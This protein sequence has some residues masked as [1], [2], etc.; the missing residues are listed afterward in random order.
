MNRLI[1]LAA[2]LLAPTVAPSQNFKHVYSS[3]G[4]PSREDLARLNLKLAWRAYLPTDHRRDGIFSVQVADD[5]ILVQTRSGAIVALNAATGST[6]WRASLDVPYRVNNVLAYNTKLVFATR[7]TTM[8]AVDR[9]TGQVVWSFSLP[10]GP[11]AAPA[12]DDLHVFI[13]LSNSHLYAYEIPQAAKK[14]AVVQAEKE[15][16]EEE[17]ARIADAAAKAK[18]AAELEEERRREQYSVLGLR[19]RTHFSIAKDFE[20]SGRERLGYGLQPRLLWEYKALTRLEQPPLLTD[21]HAVIPGQDGTFVVTA[22]TRLV[23]N[24]FTFDAG[25]ALAAPLGHYAVMGDDDHLVEIAY[26]ATTDNN[27]FAIDTIKGR[28]DWRFLAGAALHSQPRVTDDDVY[29]A[30][31]PSGLYRIDRKS[32]REHWRNLEARRFLAMNKKFVY[33]LNIRGNLLVLDRGSGQPLGRLFVHDFTAVSNETNDRIFLTSNDGM[34]LC[35]HDRD[36]PTPLR[37]KNLP[38]KKPAEDKLKIEP[39]A[40]EKKA[41]ANDR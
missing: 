24:P 16:M 37:N 22:L 8:Y 41:D 34:I 38:V 29:V 12:A 19:R 10:G 14:E 2:L 13:T 40:E 18:L 36:Y 20:I 1:A 30:A 25:E 28:I 21:E 4:A 6:L 17:K 39:R 9:A 26:V 11:S 33:A 15:T 7:A 27:L 31:D 23:S 5:Q 35:L 3:P 32:G